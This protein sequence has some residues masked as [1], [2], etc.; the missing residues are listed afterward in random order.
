MFIC[1]ISMCAGTLRA[2]SRP[3]LNISMKVTHDIDEYFKNKR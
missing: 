1:A 3:I 2:M